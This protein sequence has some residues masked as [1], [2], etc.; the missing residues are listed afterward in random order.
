MKKYLY[1]YIKNIDEIISSNNVT[2][3]IIDE[4]LIKISFFQHERI[5]HLWVTITY[6]IIFFLSLICSTHYLIFSFVSVILVCFLIPYIR[7]YFKLENG[8]QYLYKQYDMMKLL[9]KKG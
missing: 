5:I 3:D 1:D 2:Q 4:H 6:A 9:N 7:H 8:V